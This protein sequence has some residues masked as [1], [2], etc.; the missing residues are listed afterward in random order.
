MGV[1]PVMTF[2]GKGEAVVDGETGFCAE[3]NN[4]SSIAE[5]VNVLL[6]DVEL[7]TRMGHAAR[8]IVEREFSSQRVAATLG[9]LYLSGASALPRPE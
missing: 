1:P 9:E 7:R 6:D 4:P 2:G 5:H 3:P 8:M